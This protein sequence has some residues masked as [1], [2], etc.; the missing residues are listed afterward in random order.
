MA[1][2]IHCDADNNDVDDYNLRITLSVSSSGG[3]FFVCCRL[4]G[5][6]PHTFLSHFI[7]PL[8]T[9]RHTHTAICNKTK[10]IVLTHTHRND[11]RKT[12]V[13]AQTFALH[14]TTPLQF[15]RA[16]TGVTPPPTPTTE[17]HDATL[18]NNMILT[19]V[20]YDLFRPEVERMPRTRARGG[21][22]EGV[23]KRTRM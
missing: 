14:N 2:L 22:T 20:I 5:L 19:G 21:Q 16:P 12:H 6:C 17:T 4:V 3:G 11:K 9:N 15:A 10:L 13:C 1:S 23:L 7:V 8:R 18:I